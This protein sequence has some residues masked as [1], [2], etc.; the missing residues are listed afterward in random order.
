MVLVS[1][2]LFLA[3]S[4]EPEVQVQQREIREQGV[5]FRYPEIANAGRFNAA[6]HQIV[7]PLV[8]TWADAAKSGNRNQQENTAGSYINGSYTLAILKSGVVSVLFEWTTYFAGAAHPSG[9]RASLNY[10]TATG[11]VLALADLFRPGV[12]YVTRL[13]DLAINS[14]IR[15][16]LA[17]LDGLRSSDPDEQ[18]EQE[19]AIIA[20]VRKGAGPFAAIFKVFTLTDTHLVLHFQ[21]AQVAHQIMGPQEVTIP[22]TALEPLLKKE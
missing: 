8:K 21:T 4:P 12:D 10:N 20:Q 5:I 14:L 18:R 15:Q 7:D 22:L 17:L 3:F 13:S 9:E 11:R 16:Q 19:R 2:V 1:F 6:V